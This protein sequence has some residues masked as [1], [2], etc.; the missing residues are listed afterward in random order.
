MF[1]HTSEGGA[2]RIRVPRSAVNALAAQRE[3]ELPCGGGLRPAGEAE[4]RESPS[5][6]FAHRQKGD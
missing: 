2:W 4:L 3:L 6:N 5:R 1:K